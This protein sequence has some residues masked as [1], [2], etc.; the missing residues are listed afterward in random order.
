MAHEFVEH[1]A[2]GEGIDGALPAMRRFKAHHR[3]LPHA[4]VPDALETIDASTAGMAAKL[5]MRFLILTA[6][7]SG[8]ARGALW[9]EID[10]DAREWRI[11]TNRMKAGGR[12]SHPA[13]R[14]GLGRAA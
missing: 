7:R 4:E 5:C 9:S 2:A 10:L 1:N 13:V 14:C 12:A 3:A 8:E 11:P 6:V